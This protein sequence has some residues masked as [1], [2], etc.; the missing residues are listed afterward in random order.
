M[1]DKHQKID[2]RD[3]P[4][5]LTTEQAAAL[6]G[7]SPYT[8]REFAREGKIPGRK[9]GQTWRFSRDGLIRWL[10]T[11]NA[12]KPGRQTQEQAPEAQ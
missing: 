2:P 7:L 11:P 5:V 3:L 9:V 1:A 12:H 8:V 4:P 6:L 10:E